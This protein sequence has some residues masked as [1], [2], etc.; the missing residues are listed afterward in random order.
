MKDESKTKKQLIEELNLLRLSVASSVKPGIK[1]NG[2]DSEQDV[3]N[4]YLSLLNESSDPIFS[5]L[6]DGT[7]LFVNKAFANGVGKK[8]K[9]IVG[10][11]IWDVFPK[12]EAD[13]RYEALRR[14]FQTKELKEIEVRV[15]RKEGDLYYITTI[16]P[17]INKNNEVAYAIC[18][19]KEITERKKAEEKLK[20]YSAEIGDLY[21][22]APC[23]Y[24]SLS[25]DGTFL[26]IN[27]TELSWLGYDR[28][29]IIGKKNFRDFLTD[30]S[31]KIFL[32]TFPVLIKQGF[33]NNLE[34][35]MVRKDGTPLY[36]LL[37][38]TAVTDDAGNFIMTRSSIFDNT[39]RK[40]VQDS[41]IESEEKFNKAF[42]NSPL[43]MAIT[44][45]NDGRFLEVNNS[46]LKISGYQR[47]E[48]IGKSISELNIYVDIAQ[49][50]YIISKVLE[51]G[52]LQDF[53]FTARTKNNSLLQLRTYVQKIELQG[54]IC[55]LSVINDVTE[56]HK[57]ESTLRESEER[58]RNIFENAAEGIY[59][60]T[61]AGRFISVNPAMAKM[62]GY[63]S[64]AEMINAITDIAAQYFVIPEERKK[65]INLM[66]ENGFFR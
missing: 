49:R 19:S 25:N 14:V 4:H 21:N 46:F 54:N 10:K 18:I 57:F 51:T 35:E 64:P 55:I 6:H 2:L 7:Y 36:V 31:S 12:E 48:V 58:Y 61:P 50:D 37:N 16:K 8:L 11:K 3:T 56:R 43:I 29:E 52:Y 42:H 27:D 34:L 65:I 59:Q 39:E 30:E 60:S 9:E 53:E 13:K 40:K 45:I 33:M 62:C 26:R 1:K 44:S 63:D 28:D 24:H 20:R 47:N 38:A 41:L 15:P 22:N 5:F 23:G 66:E 17:V 32:R